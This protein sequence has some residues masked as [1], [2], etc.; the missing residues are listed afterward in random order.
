MKKCV[1]YENKVCTDCGEC[2]VCDLDPNK[3]CD[4]CGKCLALDDGREFSSVVIRADE[5]KKGRSGSKGALS[6]EEKQLMAFLDEPIDLNVPEPL[7][8]DRELYEKWE[9]IL[10]GAEETGAAG[11]GRVHAA[12]PRANYAIRVR[13]KR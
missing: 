13:R 9:R 8:I 12:K 5:V 6:E 10:A 11:H 7:Q 3:L 2:L 1:L 4:N